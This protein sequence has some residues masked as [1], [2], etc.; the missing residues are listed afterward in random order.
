MHDMHHRGGVDLHHRRR[1]L[2]LPA[3]SAYITSGL[4]PHTQRAFLRRLTDDICN[5]D[6]GTLTPMEVSNAPVLMSAW[7]ANEGDHPR[8]GGN[9]GGNGGHGR[10][11]SDDGAICGRERA[12]A[13]EG[14]LKRIIDER[15][16]GNTDAIAR[17]EDYNAVM[18]SWATSGER[19]AAAIRVEQV[20]GGGCFDQPRHRPAHSQEPP[21]SPMPNV[22]HHPLIFVTIT[23]PT[24]HRLLSRNRS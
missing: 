9:G 11:R 22:I 7:I 20:R 6:P 16:A 4:P 23:C 12:L 1:L 13:V 8:I 24:L 21:F 2:I 3:T 10:R 18:K 15:R 5:T 14:L 17:T 19:S